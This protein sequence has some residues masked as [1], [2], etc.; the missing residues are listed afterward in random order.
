MQRLSHYRFVRLKLFRSSQVPSPTSS[1]RIGRHGPDLI[2][3]DCVSSW[4][5]CDIPT[6]QLTAFHLVPTRTRKN[7]NNKYPPP[8]HKPTING[9]A[10]TSPHLPFTTDDPKELKPH[11][12]HQAAMP[13]SREQPV[14][15]LPDVHPSRDV[16]TNFHQ[17][18]RGTLLEW[19]S[20]ENF[21]TR[22]SSNIA[23]RVHHLPQKSMGR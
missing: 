2:A 7:N 22:I 10:S 1:S 21:T 14:S 16:R 3:A 9:W 23:S 17:I 12:V 4:S 18:K 15:R 5:R 8:S 13:I 6:Q 19:Y 11:E 20:S